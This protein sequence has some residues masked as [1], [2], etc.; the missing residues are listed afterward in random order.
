MELRPLLY[1]HILLAKFRCASLSASVYVNNSC[2]SN[3]D[4]SLFLS[5]KLKTQCSCSSEICD[6]VKMP[7]C[8]KTLTLKRKMDAAFKI[9]G[10]VLTVTVTFLVLLYLYFL[11]F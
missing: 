4:M 6:N 8:S 7:K 2:I 9:K 3:V 1:N 10:V 11:L 5:V